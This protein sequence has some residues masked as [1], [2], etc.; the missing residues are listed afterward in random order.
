M[1]DSLQFLVDKGSLLLF[2]VVFAEQIGLPL[3]AIP[4]LFAAGALAQVGKMSL[5]SAVGLPVLACLL[6][7]LLWYELGRRR[8]MRVLSWLCRIS[9]EPD[10]CVRRTENV[11]VRYGVRSLAVAKFIPGLTTVAPPLAGVFGVRPLRFLLYDGVGAVLWVGSFVGLGYLFS[12]RF[13]GM[14]TSALRLGSVLVVGL[15]AAMAVYVAFKY[16]QRQ[17][18]LRRLRVARIDP[19]ELWDLMRSGNAL[20]VVDLRHLPDVEAAPYTI[21]GALRMSPDEVAQR[22]RELPRD[23][24]LI[25]YCS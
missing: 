25:L 24:D 15:I 19:Q 11:F 17:R 23:R 14:V 16:A 2:G 20:S 18:L 10:S 9:L 12:R 1:P 13:E 3:P 5:A 21:P 8:G 6:G 22:H 7:D 4:F